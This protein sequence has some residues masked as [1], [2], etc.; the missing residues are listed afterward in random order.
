MLNV[1]FSPGVLNHEFP[2]C[3][4]PS[5]CSNA[6]TT[7]KLSMSGIRLLTS[8]LVDSVLLT[9]IMSYRFVMVQI[10]IIF[11]RIFTKLR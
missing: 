2:L 4:R 10:L 3:P 8:S 9:H 1:R 11:V 6:D 7:D 5:D